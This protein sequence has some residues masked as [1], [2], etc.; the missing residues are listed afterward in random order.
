MAVIMATLWRV[1][2]RFQETQATGEKLFVELSLVKQARTEYTVST[3][4]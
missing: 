4:C 1:K 2:M 3:S